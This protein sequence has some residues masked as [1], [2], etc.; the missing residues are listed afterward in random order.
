MIRD[1]TLRVL[2]YPAIIERLA[3][4]AHT[5][6]G[7]SLCQSLT[8]LED[9]QEAFEALEETDDAFRRLL[10]YGDLPFSGISAIEP[11]IAL[12]SAGAALE[13]ADLIRIAAFLRAVDRMIQA[14]S[15]QEASQDDLKIHAR[16][17]SLEALPGLLRRLEQSV[18]DDH[19]LL[20]G[21]SDE[22]R[23]IRD[24]L[25]QS[26]AAVRRELEKV[27]AKQADALQEPLITMR[28]GRYVVPVRS[29]RR[30]AV[31]GIVHDTS[32]T[33]STLF[34]EPMAVVDLNNRIRELES[35]EEHEVLR[36]RKELSDKVADHQETFYLDIRILAQLDFA[37]A[38]ARLAD[39]DQ[40]AKP[41][42]NDQGLILLKK[43]RHPLIPRDRVVPIDFE[44][45]RSFRTLVITGPNTGGK[46][47]SLKTCGLLSLMGMAG[48]FI[49]AADGSELAWF[50][51]LEADI[52]DEQSIEQSLSTFSSH[53]REIILITRKAG[54]GMLVLLDELG[55][56]TDPS[57]GAAL[58]IAILDFLK[59]SGCH[60]VATT[61]YRELKGYAM[62]EEGVENA[63]CEFDTQ[64]LQPTY[65]LLIGVP[66]VSNAFAISERLGLSAEIIGRARALITEEGAR[67]E[68]LVSAI[69]TS[70]KEARAMEEEIEGLRQETRQARQE[71]ERERE[72][73][74]AESRRILGQAHRSAEDLLEEARSEIED[75]LA[76]MRAA[77][78]AGLTSDH[79]IES[80]ARGRLGEIGRKFLV[81]KPQGLADD[82]ALQPEDIQLGAAYESR[83]LGVR[84][85]VRELPDAR[86]QLTLE[87]GSFRITVHVSDLRPVRSKPV[88]DKAAGRGRI[89]RGSALRSELVMRAGSELMLL[90]KRVDEALIELDQFLDQALLAGLSPVR[91][92]HGKGT[93]ALR[94]ATH[95]ALSRDRR[96][97]SFRQG[98]QGEGGDG[99]TVAELNLS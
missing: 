30:S 20:D 3:G 60:T 92:V 18:R 14:V 43:A 16:A 63:C 65:R 71:L 39:Q 5:A 8:P 55:A 75:L 50:S 73:L 45:G 91:I 79:R 90:G 85:L 23:A 54:P 82:Q 44:L 67:F 22:L 46:T 66:G 47:V 86:G 80:Q 57:E 1:K 99:V 2:E 59:A 38:K 95:E 11:T 10:K 40:A 15:G 36:I 76:D 41:L 61:H 72:K 35:A 51:A 94:K 12:A 58:A 48:L 77:Q 87:S 93:G 24:K 68:D 42:L 31:R 88:R 53:L 6:A 28:G 83:S 32:S 17:R 34:I 62:T 9:F 37:M 7:R 70:H 69:E 74:E 13:C 56:G 97:S 33:G 49:P 84:G 98:G 26:Q 21:A 89:D 19:D 25:R 96:I 4:L 81:A 64:S 78:P 27:L 29:D 52:G